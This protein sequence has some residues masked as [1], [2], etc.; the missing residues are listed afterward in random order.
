M[1]NQ[2]LKSSSYTLRRLFSRQDVKTQAKVTSK[3]TKPEYVMRCTG[4]PAD[5]PTELL[6]LQIKLYA[7]YAL[8]VRLAA[9]LT[10]S[11]LMLIR[12]EA[13][14]SKREVGET[15]LYTPDNPGL[16][17]IIA[18]CSRANIRLG[19]GTL[20]LRTLTPNRRIRSCAD[21]SED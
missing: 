13:Y 10:M 5:A 18:H 19:T 2:P 1:R 17:F 21:V 6:L 8:P 7:Y 11:V 20:P 14:A 3:K 4:S 16:V 15:V 12:R 9:R